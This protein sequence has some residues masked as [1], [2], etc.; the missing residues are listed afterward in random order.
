MKKVSNDILNAIAP[1][2]M[3]CSTCTGCKYG[4][5]SFHAKELLRLLD[6]HKEFL[7]K[8]LKKEYRYKLDEFIIFQKKLKKYANPKCGGCRNGGASGCS[9]KGCFIN[10]CTKEHNVN[11]C[12]EC[13]LFPCDKVNS[14]VFKDSIIKKWLDGNTRIKQIGINL[15]YEE[16][17]NIPHYINHKKTK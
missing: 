2:S 1:C 6:G 15:Y 13:S 11:F 8:N 9:I 12:G 5:I 3:F 17:K 10:E 7:E 4:D 14:T 16:R